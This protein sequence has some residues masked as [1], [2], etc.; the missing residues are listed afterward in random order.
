MS[1]FDPVSGIFGA[2]SALKEVETVLWAPSVVRRF[3]PDA[4][5]HFDC[6]RSS[7]RACVNNLGL[8]RLSDGSGAA[9]PTL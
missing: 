5:I 4:G 1:F 6:I 8:R 7:K 9:S 2:V 3:E